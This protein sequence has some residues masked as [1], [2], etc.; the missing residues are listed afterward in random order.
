MIFVRHLLFQGT[1]FKVWQ[2]SRRATFTTAPISKLLLSGDVIFCHVVSKIFDE[3]LSLTTG[4][5]C[6]TTS[7]RSQTS[8]HS[9]TR[10]RATSPRGATSSRFTALGEPCFRTQKTFFGWD[11]IDEIQ[12]CFPTLVAPWPSLSRTD[13][14]S[15][16]GLRR[17]IGNNKVSLN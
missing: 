3:H 17:W 14:S 10:S 9:R 12:L 6:G 5:V 4:T 8:E 7:W 2:S 16:R 13:R 1:L 15:T 11:N